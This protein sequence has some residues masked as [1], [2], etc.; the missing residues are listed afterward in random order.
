LKMT[1]LL[2]AKNETHADELIVDLIRDRAEGRSDRESE[3]LRLAKLW[4][5][6]GANVAERFAEARDALREREQDSWVRR[7]RARRDLRGEGPLIDA[8]AQNVSGKADD[9]AQLDAALMAESAPKAEP[10]ADS[11]EPTAEPPL[12]AGLPAVI[13]QS[14]PLVPLNDALALMNSKYAILDNVGGKTV[15][16]CWEES[17]GGYP[18]LIYQN[19]ESFLLRYS[20]ATITIDAPDGRGGLRPMTAS[21]A[22]WWLEHRDREQYRGVR[23]RP[24]SPRVVNGYVNSWLGWGVEAR[25][26]IGALFTNIFSRLSPTATPNQRS[27][28]YAGWHGQSKTQTSKRKSALC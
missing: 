3:A 21:L 9:K 15:I 11:A 24:N 16:G 22:R 27:T 4:G 18:K 19:K 5:I 26:E 6:N 28:S 25:P 23:F 13:P 10:Q 8:T 20:N 7:F 17:D 14:P 2:F 1:A 12:K